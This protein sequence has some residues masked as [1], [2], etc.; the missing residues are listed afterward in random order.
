MKKINYKIHKFL[1]SKASI[2]IIVMVFTSVFI[3]LGNVAL[4][5][6]M[7]QSRLTHKKIDKEKAFQ[8]AEAGI[9]Y[10]RWHLAHVS[11]DYQDGTGSEGPYIH[12]YKDENDNRIGQFSLNITPPPSGSTIVT[13]KSTGCLGTCAGSNPVLHKTITLKMGIPSYTTYAAVSNAS[14]TFPETAEVWGP[15]HSNDSVVFDGVAHSKVTAVNSVTTTCS[16]QKPCQC[17]PPASGGCPIAFGPTR[18]LVKAQANEEEISF[19]S[20]KDILTEDLASETKVFMAAG[21]AP[22]TESQT[23]ES[24]VLLALAEPPIIEEGRIDESWVFLAG[25]EAPVAAVDFNRITINLAKAKLDSQQGGIYLNKSDGEGYHVQFKNT[26]VDIYE[27]KKQRKCS[28]EDPP[29]SG[30]FIEYE[31]VY[32]I[33]LGPDAEEKFIYNDQES[34]GLNLPSNGLIFVQD[35]VWVDGT[36]DGHVTVIAAEDPLA[37]SKA[38]I[39]V[40][41]DLKYA[42][43]DDTIGLVAQDDILVGFY[44]D[45]ILN[46][47]GA[48]MSQKGRVRRLYYEPHSTYNPFDCGNFITRNKIDLHGSMAS[49]YQYGFSYQDNT[50]YTN[51]TYT[52]DNNLVYSPPPSFPTTGQYSVLSWEED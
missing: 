14:L 31:D 19:A 9:N 13:I 21:K 38:K 24:E 40:N 25:K 36:V 42:G 46:I 34:I 52:F 22:V 35:N 32:S 10:Y 29:G 30:K 47:D 45:N 15:I 27:V 8:I 16:F 18:P 1:K 43:D 20:E 39:I 50:G 37:S 2:L 44:S 48:L 23:K 4:Q 6:V 41:H 17:P 5:Y 49:F 7:N 3:I 28:Y 11:D 26:T 12:D 33:D 51:I